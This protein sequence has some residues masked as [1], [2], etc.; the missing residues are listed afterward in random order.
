MTADCFSL[1]LRRLRGRSR[2][3]SS[4]ETVS[5]LYVLPI[6]LVL[7]TPLGLALRFTRLTA[8]FLYRFRLRQDRLL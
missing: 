2:C 6:F 7:A 8:R 5:S 3:Y 4:E 1:E